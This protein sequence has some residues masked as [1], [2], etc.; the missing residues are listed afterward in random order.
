MAQIL[1]PPKTT[2]SYL[3]GLRLCTAMIWI[4]DLPRT[5]P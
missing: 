1:L 5:N 3:A 4:K 2:E